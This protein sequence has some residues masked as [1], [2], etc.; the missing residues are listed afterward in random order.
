MMANRIS[1]V[2]LSCALVVLAT[3]AAS[4]AAFTA[5][6]NSERR[7]CR[8]DAM[9]FCRNYVPNVRRITECMERNVRRLSPQCRRHFN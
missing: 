9:K 7:D 6:T 4:T 1:N 8:P 2:G 5:G 3:I